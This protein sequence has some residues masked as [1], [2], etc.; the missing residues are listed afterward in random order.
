MKPKIFLVLFLIL[1]ACGKAPK[2]PPPAPSLEERLGA[3]E[4]RLSGLEKPLGEAIEQQQKDTAR[5]SAQEQ[6][7]ADLKA[8]LEARPDLSSRLA[9]LEARLA[10]IEERIASASRRAAPSKPPA[11]PKPAPA[12][13]VLPPPSPPFSLEAID[14]Y[15]DRAV[16]AIR[17]PQGLHRLAVGDTF[18]GWTLAK[19]FGE[20][21]VWVA[22]DGRR[23]NL[24]A[25]W[26]A[27]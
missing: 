5:V 10:G 1:S 8:A 24:E 9:E 23:V 12:P 21:A 20:R 4:K 13:R 25:Q 2:S 7:L 11:R 27:D 26:R 17:T 14:V 16:A 19:A 22:P 6:A 18:A 3:L 15:G